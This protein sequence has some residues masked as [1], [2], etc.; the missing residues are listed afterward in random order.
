MESNN[1]KKR[2]TT[3]N[4]EKNV[5]NKKNREEEW[6]YNSDD[7]KAAINFCKDNKKTPYQAS[8]EFMV[9]KSTIRNHLN[10]TSSS[11]VRGRPP[12]FT[13]DEES[14]IVDFLINISKMGYGLDIGSFRKVIKDFVVKFQKDSPFRDDMPGKDWI[15]G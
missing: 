4:S 10:E 12:V 7:L 2:K 1:N 5:K 6:E 14:V 3:D 13:S 9:P 15:S 8:K 11:T